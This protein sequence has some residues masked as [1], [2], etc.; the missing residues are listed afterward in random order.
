MSAE[1]GSTS[2]LF[3][4]SEAIE[5]YLKATDRGYIAQAAK[6]NTNLVIA[7]QGSD[8]YYDEVIEIDL[9][10]SNRISTALS[11][12]TSRTLSPNSPRMSRTARGH[13]TS[14]TP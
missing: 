2:C 1:I 7:D 11:P 12:P 9:T 3:P 8:K 13:K 14:R 4:H 5:R 10:L 6:N